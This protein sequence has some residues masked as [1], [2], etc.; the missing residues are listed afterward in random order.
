[1][2]VIRTQMKTLS[3]INPVKKE[4]LNSTQNY[5][6]L[7]ILHNLLESRGLFIAQSNI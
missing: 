6:P 1:M 2:K 4:I 7:S 5:K 3:Y